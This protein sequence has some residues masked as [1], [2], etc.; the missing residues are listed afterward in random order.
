MTIFKSAIAICGLSQRDAAEFLD[1]SVDTVKS[2]SAGRNPVPDGVWWELS[3]LYADM[4]N[5]AH[6]CAQYQWPC[7]G[8]ASAVEAMTRLSNT[9]KPACL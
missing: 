9:K 4:R 8:T 2:W 3:L 6:G 7:D 5:A 1:V